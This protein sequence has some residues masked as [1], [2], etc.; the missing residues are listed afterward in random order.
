MS[1]AGVAKKYLPQKKLLQEKLVLVVMCP[2]RGI[3][4]GGKSLGIEGFYIPARNMKQASLLPITSIADL[5]E[6][7]PSVLT[8]VSGTG[9][10]KIMPSLLNSLSIDDEISEQDC[11][12][13][14]LDIVVAGGHNILLSGPPG[15]SKSMLAKGLPSLLPPP[16]TGNP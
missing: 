15:T 8:I 10:Q 5:H 16:H 1:A 13:R 4:L 6:S 2:I 7:S 12:K 3:I 9:Y 11:V 14:A